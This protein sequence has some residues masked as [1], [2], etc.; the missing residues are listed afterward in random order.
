[1]NVFLVFTL[2]FVTTENSDPRISSVTKKYP[3]SVLS[4]YGK[5]IPILPQYS[6]L[7]LSCMRQYYDIFSMQPFFSLTVDLLHMIHSRL[8]K[9]V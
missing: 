3:I 6:T 7:C 4:P 1:M 8:D 2:V 9:A 5:G